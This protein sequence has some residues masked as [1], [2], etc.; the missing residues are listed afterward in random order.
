MLLLSRTMDIVAVNLILI[1]K[2]VS[3]CL[4]ISKKTF[5]PNFGNTIAVSEMLRLEFRFNN[6]FCALNIFTN[7]P[8]YAAANNNKNLGFTPLD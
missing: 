5:V 3:N 8:K 4:E 7:Y 2:N 1:K 6:S